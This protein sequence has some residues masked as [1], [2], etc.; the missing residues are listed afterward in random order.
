MSTVIIFI[1]KSVCSSHEQSYLYGFTDDNTNLNTIDFYVHGSISQQTLLPA[2]TNIIGYVKK[3]KKSLIISNWIFID[4]KN[5]E[6]LIKEVAINNVLVPLEKCR[7]LI[8]DKVV[9]LKSELIIS[10]DST[11]DKNTSLD[12]FKTLTLSLKKSSEHQKLCEKSLASNNLTKPCVIKMLTFFGA[13]LTVTNILH[14]V[15]KFSTLGLHFYEFFKNTCWALEEVCKRKKITLKTGNY[16]L[17]ACIDIL[18]GLLVLH[19]FLT[20]IEPLFLFDFI[21][22]SSEV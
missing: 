22:F 19:V 3:K 9:F 15:L 14:F 7:T 5:G 6:P 4:V 2:D 21:S 17:G 10:E 20:Y 13:L 1:P 12:H 16:F 8:Y 11:A 18:S